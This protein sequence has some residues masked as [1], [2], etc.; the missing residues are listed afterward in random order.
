[1]KLL[2][3]AHNI[4]EMVKGPAKIEAMDIINVAI[5]LEHAEDNI[6]DAIPHITARLF[7][8][9]FPDMAS[10]LP[11]GVPDALMQQSLELVLKF[12][13]GHYR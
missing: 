5:E 2:S 10:T 11:S 12:G 6:S 7:A 13:N 3:L 8:I 4:V 1:M 9:S